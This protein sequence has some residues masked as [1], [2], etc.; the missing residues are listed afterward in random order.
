MYYCVKSIIKMIPNSRNLKY[1][2]IDNEVIR[3][4]KFIS[5]DKL[6]IL[7]YHITIHLYW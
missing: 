5:Y 3:A 4:I 1:N 6:K 2:F 7:L